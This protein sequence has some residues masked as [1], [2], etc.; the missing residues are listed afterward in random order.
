MSE[1]PVVELDTR[2]P[3]EVGIAVCGACGHRQVSV[4]IEGAQ[5]PLE[6]ALCHYMA[7][8]F[9]GAENTSLCRE[10]NGEPNKMS[11]NIDSITWL[12]FENVRMKAGDIRQLQQL[13]LPEIC[14]LE[15]ADIEY[16][17]PEDE[18]EIL[19]T[20]NWWSG[21]GSGRSWDDI[22]IQKV[23]PKLLGSLTGVLTWESGD[24]HSGFRIVD[25]VV[26]EHNVKFV[27][28]EESK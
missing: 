16:A 6:C 15:N 5:R 22:F 23:A 1:P 2:R 9:E 24:S 17:G 18:V 25:G 10:P 3:H 4:A 28:E 7:S 20:F 19:K 27:L 14:F 11:Y 13:E 21:E 8:E 12:V 26:T